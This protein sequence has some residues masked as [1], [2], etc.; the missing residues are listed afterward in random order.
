M[1]LVS[2]SPETPGETG[3]PIF[4][5]YSFRRLVGRA[6]KLQAPSYDEAAK[7]ALSLIPFTRSFTLLDY[8]ISY[9]LFHFHYNRNKIRF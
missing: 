1:E 4:L 2:S 6:Y 9:S 7:R 8:M 3:P 5:P